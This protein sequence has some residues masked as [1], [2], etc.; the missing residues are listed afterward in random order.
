MI[1]YLDDFVGVSSPEQALLNYTQCGA[2]LHDLGLQELPSKACPP[3]TVLT[4][5]GVEVNS[6]DLALSVTPERRQDLETLLLQ[7]T[8]RGSLNI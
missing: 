3:S 1:N 5:L 7:W 8:T 4:C 6:L 2:L